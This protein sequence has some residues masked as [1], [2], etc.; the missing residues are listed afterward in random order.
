MALEMYLSRTVH[1]HSKGKVC[2]SI[3]L[4]IFNSRGE[5]RQMQKLMRSTQN[6]KGVFPSAYDI[7]FDAPIN[8][9]RNDARLCFP[10]P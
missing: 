6:T 5:A 10:K 3:W 8:W 4:G 9:Q 1:L 7:P 2:V